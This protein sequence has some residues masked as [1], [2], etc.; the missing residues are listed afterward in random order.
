[1]DRK[2]VALTV[3]VQEARLS[4]DGEGLG[5]ALR[6]ILQNAIKFGAT[7]AAP[8]IEIHAN[9]D[10]QRL[11]VS[12]RDNGIGFDMQ[13]HDRIFAMFERLHRTDAYPGTGIGLAIARKAIER[14]G[15]RIWAESSQGAGATFFIELPAI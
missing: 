1:L 3:D 11:S 10:N 15:G 9:Y 8:R 14:A 4:M 7:A 5:I 2:R 12:V 6:N 13:Y